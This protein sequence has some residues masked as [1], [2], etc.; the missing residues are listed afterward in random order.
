M[1]NIAKSQIEAFAMSSAPSP[2][3]LQDVFSSK[4]HSKPAKRGECYVFNIAPGGKNE[5]ERLK[6]T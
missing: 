6:Q 1:K 2:R 5:R 4:R 3:R